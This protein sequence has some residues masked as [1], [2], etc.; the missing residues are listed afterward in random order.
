MKT[1]L[2]ILFSII[3][4]HVFGNKSDSIFSLLDNYKTDTAKI[5]FLIS[6]SNQIQNAQPTEA[7]IILKKATEFAN[8]LNSSEQQA[9]ISYA[10]GEINFNQGNYKEGLSE[11]FKAL[12][13]Y[14]STQNMPGIAKSYNKIG[15]IYIYQGDYP[16]A[17]NFLLKSLEINETIKDSSGIS[18][19][20][21]NIGFIFFEQGKYDDALK[22][23]FSSIELDKLLKNEIK[24]ANT[25]NNIGM[26]YLEIAEYDSSLFYFG[27]SLELFKEYNDQINI[28]SCYTNIAL[29]HEELGE[30]DTAI[31]NYSESLKIY[32]EIGAKQGIASA[33]YNLGYFHYATSKD[34]MAI[35]YL[36]KSL[37]IGTEI[38]S[39][40][41]MTMAS[42]ILSDIYSQ[43]GNYKEAYSNFVLY[44]NYAQHLT[45]EENI[46]KMTQI[47]M[48]YE[49]DKKQKEIEFINQQKELAH[50]AEIKRQ[51]ILLSSMSIG[52]LF[53]IAFA[54]FIFRSYRRKK[55]DNELLTKQK[56][57]ITLQHDQIVKQK[58]EITDSIHYA[59]RIQTALLPPD[60]MID[61]ILPDYF[62][63]YK[64][65]DIVSGDYY[66]I[67]QK[68][69][70]I[71]VVAADCTGHGVPGAFMSMLGISFLNEIVNQNIDIQSNIILDELRSYVIRSL[72]QTGKTGEAKDGMDLAMIIID[73]NK[74]E[75]QFS[76]AYNPLYL[77]KNNELTQIKADKMP[78]GISDKRDVPFTSTTVSIEKGDSFYLFS[79]GYVD[80]FGGPDDKKFKS[81]NFQKVLLEIQDKSMDKQKEILHD[82]IEAWK[83]T[84]EQIDDII[85]VGVKV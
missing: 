84:T 81:K 60:E 82:K 44:H 39:I 59:K 63:Y 53:L 11:L 4:I 7:L 70:K 77:I 38:G 49:F 24:T 65:R 52:V 72:R 14:E 45:N 47:E 71:I 48:Q 1:I 12:Y 32:E 16:E 73:F 58:R 26:V 34:N 19:T 21:T 83:G 29:V 55:K 75:V 76:G 85:V 22:Y 46:K 40:K 30:F 67:T 33:L 68:D 80:Q 64:P 17:L 56:A 74:K 50:Q 6:Q 27:K 10:M 8:R 23:F 31:K 28:A 25:F 35:E 2:I 66:W 78:I 20:Y 13:I 9:T 36:K 79:D 61:S 43:N 3:F 42:E 37:K 57:E 5:D 54:I 15:S 51:R 41:D 69:Q 18:N 62:I